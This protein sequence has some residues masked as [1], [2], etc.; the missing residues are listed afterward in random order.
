MGKAY[1]NWSGGKDSALALWEIMEAGQ[2]VVGSLLTTVN[3]A[4]MR[5]SMHGVP[6][7]LIENQAAA[8]GL[9][10]RTVLLPEQPDMPVYEQ[11]MR[12]A[13][14]ELKRE[15]MDTGVFGDIFLEDLRKYRESR[16]AESGM[17]GLFP[18]WKKDTRLLLE[19]FIDSGFRAVVVCVNASVLDKSFCG[20]WLNREFLND[21]PPGVDPCGENGEFHSFVCEGPVFRKPVPVRKGE[22]VLRHYRAP[23]DGPERAGPSQPAEFAYYFCDLLPG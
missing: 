4:A 11:K 2:P 23:K 16:L 8:L 18:L 19:Y 9:P 21:L 6:T 22:I 14:M 3:E 20:R 1:M 7:S 15:N 17:K 12:S 13:L 5:V 10:L